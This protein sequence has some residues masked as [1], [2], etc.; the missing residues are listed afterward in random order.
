MG[1][2]IGGGACTCLAGLFFLVRPVYL[3]R[4]ARYTSSD[5]ESDSDD[6]SESLDG[7]KSESDEEEDTIFALFLGGALF[8][9]FGAGFLLVAGVESAFKLQAFNAT[10]T[11]CLHHP[12]LLSGQEQ[13]ASLLDMVTLYGVDELPETFPTIFPPIF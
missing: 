11:L 3:I 13:V 6:S 9:A 1:W 2:M 5:S 8:L 4:G 7:S 12:P 10:A